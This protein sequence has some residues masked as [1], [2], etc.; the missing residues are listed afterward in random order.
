[1]LSPDE[2]ARVL[3]RASELAANAETESDPAHGLPASA[4]VA[5]AAE[6]GI[7]ADAV[8]RAIA[9]ERLGAVPTGARGDS[10]VGPRTVVVERRL[11]MPVAEVMARLDEWLVRGHHLRRE[12][13]ASRDAE[14]GRRDG[15]VA[16]GSRAARSALGEGRLGEIR[17]IRAS[18]RE[19]GA[20]TMLR[21]QLDRSATRSGYAGG[22]AAVA[23]AGTATG[24]V[25]A[26]A[27]FPAFVLIAPAAVAGGAGIARAGRHQS[28]K[29]AREAGRVLDA[30]GGRVNPTTLGDELRRR[31]R[32]RRR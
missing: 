29:L 18:A 10:L 14:W 4:V 28:D 27:V 15:L 13:W 19:D 22:G 9:L 2:V 30:I 21:I 7:S 12:Q 16:A 23:A 1:M 20:G 6:V 24:A 8:H 26:V 11:A 31:V 5:A 3:R 17:A 25:L 32:P